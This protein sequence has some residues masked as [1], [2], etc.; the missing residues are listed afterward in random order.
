[1]NWLSTEIP[2]LEKLLKQLKEDSPAK[3]GNMSAWH[4]LEH[5]GDMLGIALGEVPVKQQ[6]PEEKT[7][8]AQAFILSEKPLPRNFKV[9]FVAD[10]FKPQTTSFEAAKQ[11]YLD[12]LR[13]FRTE[14]NNDEKTAMHPSFGTMNRKYWERLNQKHTHH[15]FMQFGL[16]E[17][18]E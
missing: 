16:V 2:E 17:M 15:H 9:P 1:M 14:F 5:L 3:W 12:Q 8:A 13:K 18:V 10:D 11:R 7:G 6:I 4:M